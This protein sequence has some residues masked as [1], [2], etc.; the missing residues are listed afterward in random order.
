L[1]NIIN[2]SFVI[3]VIFIGPS[4]LVGQPGAERFLL[5]ENARYSQ[6]VPGIEAFDGAAR[7]I[8]WGGSES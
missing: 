5:Q 2:S 7:T 1:S 3:F 6:E 8:G 4:G